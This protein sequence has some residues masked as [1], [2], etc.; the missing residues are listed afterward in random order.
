MFYIAFLIFAIISIISIAKGAPYVPTKKGAVKAMVE[1]SDIK[2][3][4]KVIDLGSGDGR[5]VIAFA[6]EGIEAHGYEINP[7]LV[8]ISRLRIW[9]NGLQ[10]NAHIHLK[11]FWSVDFREFNIV[12]MFGAR[13]I[14]EE[15]EKKL[16]T[17]LKSGS[18]IVSYGFKIPGWKNVAKEDGVILYL[19]S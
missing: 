14:L 6:K 12:A 11:S 4:D 18:R 2:E 16:S 17:E 5:I 19:K 10:K 13:H 3:G 1:L 7:I 15:L 9:R 8:I